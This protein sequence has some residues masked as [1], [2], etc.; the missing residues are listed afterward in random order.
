MLGFRGSRFCHTCCPL[1]SGARYRLLKTTALPFQVISLK[2]AR[3]RA[4]TLK[5]IGTNLWGAFFQIF[6]C[7]CS[8]AAGLEL[9]LLNLSLMP[10]GPALHDKCLPGT[11]DFCDLRTKSGPLRTSWNAYYGAQG[12]GFPTPRA[13]MGRG[14]AGRHGQLEPCQRA[15]REPQLRTRGAGMCGA[16]GD[17]GA[18]N[19]SE[20]A[21][22]PGHPGA[23]LTYQKAVPFRVAGAVALPLSI[24]RF[25]LRALHTVGACAG[26]AG[27]KKRQLHCSPGGLQVTFL[28]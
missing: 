3:V 15:T 28:T 12:G 7:L 13:A 4:W 5:H 23:Q 11:M 16:P 22:S 17:L 19:A 25:G 1:R 6:H 9:L 18:P 20:L 24:L 21:T 2:M 14:V 8:Y 27:A 10:V 26:D